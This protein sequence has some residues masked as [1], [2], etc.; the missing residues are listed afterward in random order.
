MSQ[1]TI[2]LR[3]G[4]S[5]G[6]KDG[7]PS[8]PGSGQVWSVTF[9]GRVEDGSNE[10]YL[11]STLSIRLMDEMNAKQILVGA[12][13]AT[14]I[15]PTYVRTYAS[16][17]YMVS[18]PTVHFSATDNPLVW[19]GL[20][21]AGNGFVTLTNQVS[22]PEDIVAVVPFQGRLA[23]FAR[24]TTQIWAVASDPLQ[25]QLAQTLINC[26]TVAKNSVQPMGDID[27][28]FLSDTGVRSL[29]SRTDSGNAF[30]DDL[31][32]A[33]DS[34]ITELI[35]T[36]FEGAS[37]AIS[38]IEPQ[39]AR[40]WLC[41]RDTIYVL[42]YFPSSKVLAWSTYKTT[43]LNGVTFFPKQF[44][45]YKGQ[46][47][48]FDGADFLYMYGGPSN[49]EYDYTKAVIELPWLDM[50][51]PVV[52]KQAE[53]IQAVCRGQWAIKV[54]MD[55]SAGPYN[56]KLNPDM[57]LAGEPVLWHGSHSTYGTGTIPYTAQGTHFRARMETDTSSRNAAVFSSLAFRYRVLEE[58]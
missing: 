51:N 12:G 57:A 33:I 38:V 13:Y 35:L 43:N 28:L 44:I 46:V 53:G 42:S 15:D 7:E 26:G 55:P 29:R 19:N 14:G 20:D 41:I 48:V 27:A 45:V 3:T 52:L 5:E 8:V 56:D 34:I 2:K 24:Q 10:G 49:R 31:G 17:V 4:M 58:E 40:Y 32:S 30:V 21:G 54:G 36:D 18:G 16:K 6:I 23:F 47:L 50:K 9:S 22:T 39:S 1:A 11:P 37:K 25:W